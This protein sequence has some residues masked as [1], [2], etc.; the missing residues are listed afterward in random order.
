MLHE[1]MRLVHKGTQDDLSDA[2]PRKADEIARDLLWQDIPV[3]AR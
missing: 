1:V 2:D 3:A